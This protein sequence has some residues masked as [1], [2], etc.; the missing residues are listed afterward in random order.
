MK[1]PQCLTKLHQPGTVWIAADMHLGPDAPATLQAF[2][3]FIQEASVKADAL[4]L[5]G[6]IFNVWIGDDHMRLPPPWLQEVCQA[7]QAYGQHRRLYIMRGNRDFLL[8]ESA[9]KHLNAI[10][11]AD[12]VS[13]H[14]DAGVIALSH[15][16]ELCT[17]DHAYQRFRHIVRWPWLQASYLTLPLRWRQAIADYFRRKSQGGNRTKASYIMDVNTKAVQQRLQDSQA[18]AVVHGHTHRPARHSIQTSPVVYRWVLP[19]W[20]YEHDQRGGYLCINADGLCLIRQ[21]HAELCQVVP[22]SRT[23]S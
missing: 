16:D 22:P 17:D 9:A 20:D 7:L 12:V 13:L 8:G 6:D 19:D 4:F 1:Q 21:Q 11:L 5:C 14:T 18:I 3:G 15:G 2:L 23:L 10:L